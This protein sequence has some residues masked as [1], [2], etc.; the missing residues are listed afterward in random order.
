MLSQPTL[1]HV[2]KALLSKRKK[3]RRKTKNQD[4]PMRNCQWELLNSTSRNSYEQGASTGSPWY[5]VGEMEGRG[6]SPAGL[7]QAWW[8]GEKSSWMQCQEVQFPPPLPSIP[9]TPAAPSHNSASPGTTGTLAPV[10]HLGC[11]I[12]GH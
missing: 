10:S 1:L 11:F 8:E 7:A 5:G 12:A 6:L 2:L 9:S 4:A 3:I